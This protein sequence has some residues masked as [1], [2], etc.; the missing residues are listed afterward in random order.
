MAGRERSM[1]LSHFELMTDD[2]DQGRVSAVL[3]GIWKS[4]LA[5]SGILIRWF[6][7]VDYLE[8]ERLQ[9]SVLKVLFGELQ[10]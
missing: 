10:L 4:T 8:D 9:I 3:L 6:S 2:V 1:R 7:N 5:A